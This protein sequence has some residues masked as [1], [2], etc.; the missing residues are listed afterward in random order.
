M[1]EP[2]FKAAFAFFPLLSGVFL[3]YVQFGIFGRFMN[4][5]WGTIY[6]L[7]LF[8]GNYVFSIR[9]P[10]N[11][12]SGGLVWPI[13][14]SG[15]L[16]WLSGKLWQQSGPIGRFV[17]AA[18]LVASLFVVITMSKSA[19]PPFNSWPTYYNLLFVEW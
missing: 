5:F 11:F 6:G 14:L 12:I 7:G 16:F 8:V 10:S 19:Q 1:S 4:L 17:E 9:S 13:L 15:L 2:V 3:P 18:L